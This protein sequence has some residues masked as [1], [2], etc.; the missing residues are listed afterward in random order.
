MKTEIIEKSYRIE[1][2][3]DPEQDLEL[4]S[5]EKEHIIKRIKNGFKQGAM[6]LGAPNSKARGVYWRLIDTIAESVSVIMTR[7][8]DV[9]EI[10]K[11]RTTDGY[12]SN[13]QSAEHYDLK[14][15][16]VM[17]NDGEI[18]FGSLIKFNY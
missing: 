10:K 14:E 17:F 12:I 16:E 7:D 13:H 18:P 3:I 2:F 8:V 1:W 11:Y 6:K 9:Y 5:F 15:F 4:R